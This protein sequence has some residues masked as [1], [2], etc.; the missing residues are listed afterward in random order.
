MNCVIVYNLKDHFA[1][2]LLEK[3]H[4]LQFHLNP[5]IRIL[6]FVSCFCL[7][8]LG[9]KSLNSFPRNIELVLFKLKKFF[10]NISLCYHIYF[11]NPISR[12]LTENPLFKK[13]SRAFI[14]VFSE[15]LSFWCIAN[16]Y[17][18]LFFEQPVKVSFGISFLSSVQLKTGNVFEISIQKTSKWVFCCM[19]IFLEQSIQRLRKRWSLMKHINRFWHSI[20]HNPPG[21]TNLSLRCLQC[22]ICQFS[23]WFF[24][25]F[26]MGFIVEICE[27]FH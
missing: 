15:E 19:D 20:E 8:F 14:K 24:G 23:Q 22:F 12:V 1:K 21:V 9:R 27:N 5:V 25:G 13:T 10:I 11:I 4:Y 26:D 17:F 6:G 16:K 18:K 2:S 3:E 7:L